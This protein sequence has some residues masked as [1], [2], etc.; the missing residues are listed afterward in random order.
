MN[1][2]LSSFTVRILVT[3]DIFMAPGDGREVKKRD[4]AAG[5]TIKGRKSIG[6][7]V[8]RHES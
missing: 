4:T 5:S 6:Q 7:E 8:I 1:P 2:L 3:N